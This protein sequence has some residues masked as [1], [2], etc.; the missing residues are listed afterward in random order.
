MKKTTET[1]LRATLTIGCALSMS[2]CLEPS[3]E[4]QR[5]TAADA[6]CGRLEQCG[7][8]G[9]G[10]RFSSFDDCVIDQRDSFNDLWPASECSDG[11]MNED[12]YDICL[13]KIRSADCNANF[14]DAL[15]FTLD[16]NA[17]EVCTDPIN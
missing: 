6:Y 12:R 11:R 17:N 2:A 1:I 9:P 8:I 13:A 10:E 5:D 15:D 4:S 16:C 7:D 14:F 3:R